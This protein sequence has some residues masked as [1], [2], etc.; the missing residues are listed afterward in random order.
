MEEEKT[1]LIILA[2]E[3][4]LLS[5]A[6]DASSFVMAAAMTGVGRLL[7]IVPLEWIGAVLFMLTLVSSASA[8]RRS[9][10]KTPQQAADFIKGRY[11]VTA[12]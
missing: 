2:T 6:R 5:W 12:Q 8:L 3:T 4:A 9:Y 7:N 1:P 10:R 11:G